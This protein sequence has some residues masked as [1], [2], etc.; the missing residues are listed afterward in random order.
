VTKLNAEINA[1]L[2]SPETK[3]NLTKFGV[4]PKIGSPR[5]FAVLVADEIE[6]WKAAAK[7]AGI[8]PE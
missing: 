8:E 2:A 4:E 5:D 7:S 1:S 6:L 3:A